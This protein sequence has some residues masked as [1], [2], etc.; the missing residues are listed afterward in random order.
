MPFDKYKSKCKWMFYFDVDEYLKL[1][2][3]KITINDYLSQDRFNK[4][5]AMKINWVMQKNEDLLY[6]DNRPLK[7]RFLTPTYV[8]EDIRTVKSIIRNDSR[9]NPWVRNLDL[10]K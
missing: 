1:V 8:K 2:D 7:E 10:M 4:C 6:Y 3:I 9:R 5:E